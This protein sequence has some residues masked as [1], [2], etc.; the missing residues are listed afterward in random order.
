MHALHLQLHLD[1][2]TLLRRYTA[3]PR[4]HNFQSQHFADLYQNFVVAPFHYAIIPKQAIILLYHVI[5]PIYYVL[6]SLPHDIIQI[7]HASLSLLHVII[8]LNPAVILSH[9]PLYIALQHC[10]PHVYHYT[11]KWYHCTCTIITRHCVFTLG[12]YVFKSCF[13]TNK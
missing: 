13:Y 6:K 12:E 8:P 11:A 3:L 9:W 1:I 4:C 5:T 7:L 10:T 2:I